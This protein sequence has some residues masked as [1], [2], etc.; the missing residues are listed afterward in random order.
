[1]GGGGRF[2][3]FWGADLAKEQARSLF[4]IGELRK[5]VAPDRTAFAPGIYEGCTGMDP[6]AHFV[7]AQFGRTRVVT[8]RALLHALIVV[9]AFLRARSNARMCYTRARVFT[10]VFCAR[11]SACGNARSRFCARVFTCTFPR[12]NARA[13]LCARVSAHAFPCASFIA[14]AFLH[15]RV[16]AR[17]RF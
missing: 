5:L 9:R 17:A 1:L 6:R 8:M 11:V 7:R 3:R 2:D 12:G 4:A 10:R 15:M 16:F 13:L 14:R